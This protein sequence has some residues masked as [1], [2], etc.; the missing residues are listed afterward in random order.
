MS[1]V[2]Y[3]N[4]DSESSDEDSKPM[5]NIDSIATISQGKDGKSVKIT[6]PSPADFDS[7]DDEPVRKKQRVLIPGRAGLFALLPAPKNTPSQKLF[8]PDCISR[9]PPVVK[10]TPQSGTASAAEKGDSDSDDSDF[11]SHSDS[12]P[13]RFFVT[14]ESQPP[15]PRQLAPSQFSNHAYRQP[16]GYGEDAMP[17]RTIDLD[18]L[19]ALEREAIQIQEEEAE[20][21]ARRPPLEPD[22]DAD[23]EDAAPTFRYR[24]KEIPL[25]TDEQMLRK[26]Q[27]RKD[28]G[29]EEINFIDVS[30]DLEMPK[31]NEIKRLTHE[32][33]YETDKPKGPAPSAQQRR[34]HQITYLAFQAKERELELKNQWAENRLTRKQTQSKYGF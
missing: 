7:D 22:P 6:I 24:E 18:Q 13:L 23:V 2:A 14:D 32:A 30:V 3:G 15:P 9:K 25:E 10:A 33:G 31:G 11:D 16:D 34:K 27:G 29:K 28:R 17:Q 4:S 20:E 1:L 5:Q 26:I 19:E 8:V 12:G 21:A